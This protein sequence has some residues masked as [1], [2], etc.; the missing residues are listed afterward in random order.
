MS[1]DLDGSKKAHSSGTSRNKHRS[2]S[3]T[4][5]HNDKPRKKRH[6]SATSSFASIPN[7]I[8]I[9]MLNSGLIPTSMFNGKY[10]SVI[11]A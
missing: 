8:K 1:S 11:I 10:N 2:R 6:A 5:H 7:A 4:R 3:T 9:S